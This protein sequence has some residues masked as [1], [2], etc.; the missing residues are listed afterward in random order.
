MISKKFGT[1]RHRRSRRRGT[2]N[3]RARATQRN[4]ALG[5][6]AEYEATARLS[7]QHVRHGESVLWRTRRVCSPDT[8][9]ASIRA[10]ASDFEG[11]RLLPQTARRQRER[12]PGTGPTLFPSPPGYQACPLSNPG[13]YPCIPDFLSRCVRYQPISHRT[14][15]TAFSTPN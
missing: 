2:E 7:N 12:V 11:L 14:D 3:A 10:A 6:G 15:R 9:L 4:R 13:I 8:E 1:A 5:E